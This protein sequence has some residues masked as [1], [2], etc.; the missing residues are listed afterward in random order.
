MDIPAGAGHPPA[1]APSM[2]HGRI[3]DEEG[4]YHWVAIGKSSQLPCLSL[5]AEVRIRVIPGHWWLLSVHMGG[6]CTL[7]LPVLPIHIS[8]EML[9]L[10]KN[11]YPIPGIITI[12]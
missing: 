9:S 7:Y 2:G 1:K 3:P 10:Q 12:S 8:K 6:C 4:Q 5:H 11:F